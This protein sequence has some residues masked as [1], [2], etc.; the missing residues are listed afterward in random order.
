MPPG[1]LDV[2]TE[3]S[4]YANKVS[5]TSLVE[6]NP[7]GIIVENKTFAN[8]MR[9]IFSILWNLSEKNDKINL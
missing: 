4:I 9:C 3:I 6:K 7:C 5:F 1:E 2:E 8:S